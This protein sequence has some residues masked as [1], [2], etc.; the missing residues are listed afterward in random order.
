MSEHDDMAGVPVA[1][2]AVTASEIAIEDLIR[3][4]AE[5]GWSMAQEGATKEQAVVGSVVSCQE[6]LN[7]TAAAI[8]ALG[9]TEA[10]AVELA[11][12]E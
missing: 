9:I 11:E 1:T 10:R 7:Q 4:A 12:R 3:Y 5:Y 8:R 2:Q 6:T